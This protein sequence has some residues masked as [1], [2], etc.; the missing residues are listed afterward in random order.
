MVIGEVVEILI[1]MRKRR[2][3]LSREEEAIIEAC[4][5][6]DRLPRLAEATTYEPRQK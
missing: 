5:L 1:G 3:V 6:L 2:D 4:N